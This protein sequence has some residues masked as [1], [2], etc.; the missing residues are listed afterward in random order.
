MFY[1][2]INSSSLP[3]YLHFCLWDWQ[4]CFWLTLF[5]VCTP[6]HNYMAPWRQPGP[7]G[8]FVNFLI[9]SKLQCTH[10]LVFFELAQPVLNQVQKYCLCCQLIIQSRWVIFPQKLFVYKEIIFSAANVKLGTF[11]N[12]DCEKVRWEMSYSVQHISNNIIGIQL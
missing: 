7:C 5:T 10:T 2:Y 3:T 9:F 1:H 8:C 12:Q 6:L 4:N 11:S